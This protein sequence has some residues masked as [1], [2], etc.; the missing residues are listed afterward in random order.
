MSGMC[1]GDTELIIGAGTIG[2][3]IGLLARL[4][5]ASKIIFSE[6][7]DVRV[8]FIKSLG[9]EAYNSL[10]DNVNTI[11]PTRMDGGADYVF[12][13][14]GAQQGWDFAMTMVK[15]N[16]TVVPVGLPKQ[17]RTVDIAKLVENN[18]TL[19]NVNV[20]NMVDFNEAVY[21]LN[22]GDIND[23]L[24]KMVT[25]IWPLDMAKEAIET[26]VDKSGADIKI[27]LKPDLE[28]IVRIGS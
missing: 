5:G 27:L 13:V 19:V 15:K 6:I 22:R 7:S 25:S 28:E 10:R 20:H 8:K 21:L 24:R 17:K 3:I 2:I 9:F 14:S 11:V 1:F 26:S 16:G 23:Q 4:N 18:L 12:E